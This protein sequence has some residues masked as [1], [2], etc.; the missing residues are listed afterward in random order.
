MAGIA[1]RTYLAATAA[2]GIEPLHPKGC[3]NSD[4]SKLL[5]LEN[6]NIL[7]LDSGRRLLRGAIRSAQQS[8]C[9][10]KLTYKEIP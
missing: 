10:I 3:E 1:A 2:A 5:N 8:K 6:K 4:F 9:I 7:L